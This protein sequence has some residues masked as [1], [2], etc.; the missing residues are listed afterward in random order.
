MKKIVSLVLISVFIISSC[1]TTDPIL[2]EN[3]YGFFY[4]EKPLSILIM[5]PINKS[6]DVE[7][8]EYFHATL[9][10][11]LANKGYYVVPAFLSMEVLKNEGAYDAEEFVERS[12][13]GFSDVFNADLALFTVIHEWKKQKALG[14]IIIEVEYII[15]DIRTN[16]QVWRRRGNFVY[17]TNKND[18]GNIILQLLGN[19]IAASTTSYNEVALY[20]N[21]YTFKDLPAGKYSTFYNK[22]QKERVQLEEFQLNF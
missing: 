13:E 8:K 14:N 3:K 21:S 19:I 16:D 2:K 7:A 17:Q 11:P 10:T 15:K 12:L 18:N 20:C 22:D 6:V 1:G 9:H 5:P 4:D